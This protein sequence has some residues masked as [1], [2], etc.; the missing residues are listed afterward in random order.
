M[1]RSLYFFTISLSLL[2]LPTAGCITQ[3]EDA[4]PLSVGTTVTSSP[5]ITLTSTPE[6]SATTASTRTIQHRQ[7][8]T[9]TPNQLVLPAVTMSPQEM[10]SAL[11]ELLSTNGNCSGKCIGGIRPDE[12]TAQDAVDIMAQ[13]GAVRIGENSQGKPFLNLEQSPLYGQINVFL[14]VGTWTKQLESIDKVLIRIE[15]ASERYLGAELWLAN[16]DA[17]VGFR[18]DNLLKTYGVPSYVGS[19]F[20]T[21]VAPGASLEG[22]TISY[23]MEIQYE[24]FNLTMSIGAIAYY[25][26]ENL[27][28]CPSSD[29]HYLW[30]EINPDR[31]LI[32]IQ[33]FYPVT[34]QALFGTDLEAFYEVF[35][36]EANPG[37]CYRTT[38]EQISALQDDFH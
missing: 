9:V 25:D 28:V 29:P 36:D 4:V 17:W 22:R 26:G 19:N 12:M 31:P 6:A 1:R 13:W 27:S 16:R 18:F 30:I 33:E 10:E 35:T 21:I 38:L 3:V 34:W 32:E 8:S 14:S 24:Q 37:A 2:C 7:T 20:R 5:P 15:D 11:L 23:G